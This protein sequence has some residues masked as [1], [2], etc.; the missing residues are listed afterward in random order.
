MHNAPAAPRWMNGR[1]FGDL[2]MLAVLALVAIC[3]S[4]CTSM[5]KSQHSR[6]G[7][8]VTG[9]PLNK[10]TLTDAEG[11]T[12]FET[13]GPT[14]VIESTPG[15]VRAQSSGM[16]TRTL[17]VKRNPQ[18]G[19]LE[20]T[21]DSGSDAKGAITADAQTGNVT[22]FN[23]ETS[24]SQP[25]AAFM[26]GQAQLREVWTHL[27]DNERQTVIESVKNVSSAA[28]DALIKIVAGL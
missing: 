17:N 2:L 21:L 16:V 4:A 12:V 6:E 11:T 7:L 14:R 13:A 18:T 23:F 22:S 9:S 5:P 26:E 25:L 20:M 15:K 27:S 3:L 10:T 24:S 8:T 19:A 1:T 28:A